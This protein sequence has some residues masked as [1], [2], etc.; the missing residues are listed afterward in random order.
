MFLF[1][2]FSGNGWSKLYP[3]SRYGTRGMR[4][5]ARGGPGMAGWSYIF[6]VAGKQPAQEGFGASQYR[7]IRAL[8]QTK[9]QLH[10]P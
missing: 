4:R 10:T 5:F 8:L 3:L 6:F 9:L 1:A 7:A 2:D